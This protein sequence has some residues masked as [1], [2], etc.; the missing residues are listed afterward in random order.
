MRQVESGGNDRAVGDGG[1]S[2]GPYQIQLPYWLD[3]GGGA[4]RY[5]LDALHADRCTPI[6]LGYWRRYC[7]RALAGG[8]LQTLARTHNGGP[9]WNTTPKRRAATAVYWRKVRAAMA[10]G[11]EEPGTRNREPGNAEAAR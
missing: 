3:G 1:R 5:R 6:I 2:I 4:G 9:K 10:A 8:D 11:A 7:P